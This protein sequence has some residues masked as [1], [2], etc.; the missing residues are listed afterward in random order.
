MS[1][2]IVYTCARWSGKREAGSSK[3]TVTNSVLVSLGCQEKIQQTGIY[4]L[5][6][7][8]VG[9]LRSG[10]QWGWFLVRALSL[11][12]GWP[13]SPCIFSWPSLCA[14]E[15]LSLLQKYQSYQI[16]APPLLPHLILLVSLKALF[17]NSH[18]E[19]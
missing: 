16:R 13:P 7:P 19:G 15:C 3:Q 14:D 1:V 10:Y 9:S 12:C 5:T 6:V 4:F 2:L 8:L 11:V 17:P 18:M